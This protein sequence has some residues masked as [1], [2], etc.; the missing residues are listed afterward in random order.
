MAGRN[1]DVGEPGS[2][3]CASRNSSSSF[4]SSVV[5][6]RHTPLPWTTTSPAHSYCRRRRLDR[7]SAARIVR[8]VTG[9]A[10]IS[11][12]VS[13]HALRHAFITAAMDA[14]LPLRYVQEAAS[15]ADPRTRASGAPL[16]EA[17]IAGFGIHRE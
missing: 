16:H 17:G 5:G 15:H 6:A 4:N 1:G 11:K 13:P 9:R 3:A 10:G 7:H 12:H 8:R 14:G 2:I